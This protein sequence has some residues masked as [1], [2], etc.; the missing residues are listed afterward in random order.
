[1]SKISL[2][3]LALMVVA[4]IV[5]MRFNYRRPK[6]MDNV[7]DCIPAAGAQYQTFDG[8]PVLKVMERLNMGKALT[9]SEDFGADLAALV[10]WGAEN[11]PVP[12]GYR[13]PPKDD[14]IATILK[15]YRQ[16]CLKAP[17]WLVKVLEELQIEEG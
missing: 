16:Q 9:R 12:E 1:M 10:N 17:R 2:T 15:G 6:V 8:E 11:T 13:L 4:G 3:L 7:A 5:L 14:I